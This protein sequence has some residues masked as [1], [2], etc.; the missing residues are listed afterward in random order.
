MP[1][2]R[3]ALPSR[4]RPTTSCG[5]WSASRWARRSACF[6]GSGPRSPS[7]LLLPLTYKVDATRGLHA[8][9]RYLL[10]RHVWRLDHVHPAQHAGRDRQPS[11][12]R[13][14]ETRWRG[15]G[16][17]AP[18]WRRPR[19]ARSWRAPSAPS[20]S[21]FS[22]GRW[23][24]SRSASVR[25]EYFALMILA[26]VTVS[27]VL[28]ASALRGLVEPRL[29]HL[30]RPD[31]HR[32]ADR[33]AA[34]HLRTHRAARRRSTSSS[35][36][37]ACSPSA[38]RSIS[39]AYQDARPTARR[40]QRRRIDLD[41]ARRTGRAPGKRGCAARPSAFPSAPCRPAA[42]RF[43]PSCPI[44]SRSGCRET[45]DEFGHGAIEGVAGPEAANNASAAGVLV[46]ML[47]LG[48]PT[49]ATAAIMLSAFQS[50]GIT[51]GPLLLQQ[52]SELVWGLIASLY[53]GNVM[54]LVLNLPL[55]GPVGADAEDPASRCSTPPFS[56]SRRSAPTASAGPRLTSLCS[57]P[58][59]SPASSC[60]AS[61]SRPRRSSSA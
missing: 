10:R 48:L 50:Y 35:S 30:S 9:R 23:W 28:G 34:L 15:A 58:W 11:S 36:P 5:A 39:P 19:S 53:I 52:Q 32:P 55:V 56:C 1:S 2:W 6:L 16:A 14:R 20:A 25:P 47:A 29:R 4:L 27:A 54:L 24:I 17:P 44:G 45:P 43:R 51:P 26:F 21:R 60:A 13:S 59:A 38:R 40:A 57:M 18:R 61:I 12:P 46:P 37:S 8:V 3:P 7:R 22:P 42:R 33:T 31:R 41:D 49:S